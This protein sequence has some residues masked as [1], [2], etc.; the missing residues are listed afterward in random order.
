MLFYLV[1][2]SAKYAFEAVHSPVESKV[3]SRIKLQKLLLHSLCVTV[4]FTLCASVLIQPID[5]VAEN[6]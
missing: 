5:L 3:N 6:T 4:L 2:R 1:V